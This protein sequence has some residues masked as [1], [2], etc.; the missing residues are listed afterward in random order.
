MY[1]PLSDGRVSR[2]VNLSWRA[3]EISAITDNGHT[4][5]VALDVVQFI[6]LSYCYFILYSPAASVVLCC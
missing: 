1:Y 6:T 2:T 5:R 3:F 4:C